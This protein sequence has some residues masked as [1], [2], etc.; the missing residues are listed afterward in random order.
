M[1]SICL[2]CA[3][4]FLLSCK[5]DTAWPTPEDLID[6][7]TLGDGSGYPGSAWDRAPSPEALG[8]SSRQLEEVNE[9]ARQNGSDALLVVD[10]GVAVWEY[11]D[12]AKVHVIQ[13]ARKSF[14]SVLYGIA[15]ARHEVD[16]TATLEELGIDDLPPS[17]TAEEKQADVE[18]LLMARSG[19]YHEA[20][21][22]SQS[23]K[24]ARPARGSHPHGTFWY[25]NNWDFNALGTIYRQRTGEDIFQS[26]YERI[27]LPLQMEDWDPGDGFYQYEAVSMH[28]AYHMNM[29]ARDMARFG[30]LMARKGR[31]R[32]SQILP[33]EW[34]ARSTRPGSDAGA[35]WNYGYLWWVGKPEKWNGRVLYA[36]RGGSGHMIVVV[37]D[38]EIVVVHRVNPATYANG[39][40]E[41]ED[42]IRQALA[43]KIL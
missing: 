2:L 27:G 36:A 33:Q 43:A 34:V 18:E 42:I 19:V 17:L 30:L 9:R 21:A 28:P 8:W 16:L 31:W 13:S 7:L 12:I 37:P 3:A 6:P 25:Y 10:R 20:A 40:T 4:L 35:N 14:L 1:K 23:M 22:E 39:W 24:D 32:Q 15:W 38:Q 41:V 11:G 5:T 29:S 26:L